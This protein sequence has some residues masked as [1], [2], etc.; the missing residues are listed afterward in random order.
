MKNNEN[1]ESH[2]SRYMVPNLERALTIIEYLLDY[3]DGLGLAELAT[4]LE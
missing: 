2:S 4:G 3:P 1:K